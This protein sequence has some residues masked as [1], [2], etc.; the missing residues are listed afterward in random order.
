MAAKSVAA[1]KL[2]CL[3][4]II[5]PSLTE[6]HRHG[7]EILHLRKRAIQRPKKTGNRA[8]HIPSKWLCGMTLESDVTHSNVAVA[9]KWETNLTRIAREMPALGNKG[10]VFC[11]FV[12]YHW[13]SARAWDCLDSQC[14]AWSPCYS[15]ENK[16]LN[17]ILALTE[18]DW[19]GG[20]RLAFSTERLV[21]V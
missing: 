3:L 2:E 16:R 1:Q 14:A 11:S 4:T 19:S 20:N 21:Q 7:D 17:V 12:A 15:K 5:A 9:A 18:V 8:V 6:S 13:D 10:K